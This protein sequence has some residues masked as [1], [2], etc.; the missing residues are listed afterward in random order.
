MDE[1][2]KLT[3]IDKIQE[4]VLDIVKKNKE[5]R[6]VIDA[7][8]IGAIRCYDLN[9]IDVAWKYFYEAAYYG[10]KNLKESKKDYYDALNCAYSWLGVMYLNSGYKKAALD[11]FE[12]I[13]ELY[14]DVK[15]DKNYSVKEVESVPIAL[16]YTKLLKK[17]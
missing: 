4:I 14:N 9:E 15:D 7:Y 3:D 16:K 5:Y 11:C 12:R 17:D 10:E 13:I 6:T 2:Y 1:I 8:M